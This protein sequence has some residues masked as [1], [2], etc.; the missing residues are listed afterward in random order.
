MLSGK[1]Q[2]FF[3]L[4]RINVVLAVIVIIVGVGLHT[5]VLNYAHSNKGLYET[6]FPN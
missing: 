4:K 2:W 1:A 5:P 3:L 6:G